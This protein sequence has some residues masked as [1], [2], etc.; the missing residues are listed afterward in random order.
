[1]KLIYFR[2]AVSN[3]GDELNTYLWQRLLPAG[4][5]DEDEA[6]LFLGIGSIIGDYPPEAAKKYVVGSGFGGYTKPPNMSDGRWTVVFVRGPRTAE[7]LGLPPE[8]AICDSAI[9][10]RRLA[11]PA[12]AAGLG[13]GYMPHFQSLERG[14]W[15]EACRRAGLR[16]IDPTAPVEQVLAEIRGVKVLITEAM[17]GAIVAD[18]LRVPWLAV[19]PIHAQHHWKWLDWADSLGIELRQHALRPSSLMEL[20]VGMVGRRQYDWGFGSGRVHRLATS[21][22]ARPVNAAIVDLAARRLRQIA[23]AEPQ[24]SSDRAIQRRTEQSEAAL[25]DFVGSRVA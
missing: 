23:E 21:P 25:A 8:K 6:E 19:K 24:L 11:L 18:A 14:L 15:A 10:L 12:P 5:L 17:H 1:M 3:F 20:Y 13:I 22:L 9:L 4:F 7:L 16:L 2:G